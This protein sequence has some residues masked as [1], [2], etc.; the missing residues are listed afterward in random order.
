MLHNSSSKW[1]QE[2]E[3]NP[4]LFMLR[5]I[6]ERIFHKI[7][8]QLQHTK[9]SKWSYVSKHFVLHCKKKKWWLSVANSCTS[10]FFRTSLIKKLDFRLY[11]IPASLG[12]SSGSIEWFIG[13]G[14]LAVVSPPLP[15]HTTARKPDS[16]HHSILSGYPDLKKRSYFLKNSD[17]SELV[18]PE[19]SFLR[20]YTLK[21]QFDTS[22]HIYDKV[23]RIQNF[24]IKYGKYR[25]F[26]TFF[27]CLQQNSKMIYGILSPFLQ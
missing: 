4:W 9:C 25:S 3:R 1:R 13:P 16:L 23:T 26:G 2:F 15:N 7:F 6:C 10:V 27:S 24:A 19:A 21:F 8:K 12:L 17:K 20:K 22:S 11:W 5:K 18:S 14:F